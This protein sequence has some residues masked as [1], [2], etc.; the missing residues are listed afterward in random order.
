MSLPPLLGLL[1]RLLPGPGLPAEKY[2]N[3]GIEFAGRDRYWMA[4]LQQ[5][6]LVKSTCSDR[7]GGGEMDLD[8]VPAEDTGCFRRV[9]PLPPATR[10]D[11]FLCSVCPPQ[12]VCWCYSDSTHFSSPPSTQAESAVIVDCGGCIL[13]SHRSSQFRATKIHP[14]GPTVLKQSRLRVPPWP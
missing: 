7:G 6:T 3:L 10:A 13:P 4:W 5:A 1:L 12:A 8:A 11:P 14:E 9:P 2:D